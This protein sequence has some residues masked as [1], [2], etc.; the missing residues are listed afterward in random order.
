VIQRQGLSNKVMLKDN[1]REA[2][3]NKFI[4]MSMSLGKNATKINI[5]NYLRHLVMLFQVLCRTIILPV[6]C[7]GVKL[8]C[9]HCG[10]KGSRGCLIIWC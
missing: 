2:R 5:F 8:G 1:K 9:L 4:S 7:M 3:K 6:V 10:R